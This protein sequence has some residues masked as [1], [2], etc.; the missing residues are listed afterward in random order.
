MKAAQFLKDN[1]VPWP[2]DVQKAIDL[3][4]QQMEVIRAT[5]AKA[6]DV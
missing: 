6:A 2:P 5:S 4:A 1:D 3:L